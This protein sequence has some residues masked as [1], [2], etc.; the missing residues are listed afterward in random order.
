MEVSVRIH[1]AVSR[2]NCT[3]G[4]IVAIGIVEKENGFV[5][6]HSALS[7]GTVTIVVC[8]CFGGSADWHGDIYGHVLICIRTS[9]LGGDV[10]FGASHGNAQEGD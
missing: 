7:L 1:G 10:L 8:R 5:D 4:K 3:C 6:I 9:L 2:G